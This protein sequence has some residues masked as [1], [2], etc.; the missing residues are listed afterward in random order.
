MI[1]LTDF[2]QMSEDFNALAGERPETMARH[3]RAI[4]QLCAL[5]DPLR[6]PSLLP[7]QQMMVVAGQ[8]DAVVSSVQA[9]ALAEHFGCALERFAGGAPGAARA[10]PSVRAR[11]GDEPQGVSLAETACSCVAAARILWV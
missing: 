6:R 10:Q 2:A 8:V 11:H 5:I 1:P 4:K 7:A 9:S 3:R